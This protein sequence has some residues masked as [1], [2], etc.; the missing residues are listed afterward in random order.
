MEVINYLACAK[1]K[2]IFVFRKNKKG[3]WK[4][5]PQLVSSTSDD[6]LKQFIANS[7]SSMRNDEVTE[8]GVK[9]SQF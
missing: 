9:K 3:L 5:I 7:G 2:F 1:H 4:E 6:L 8:L